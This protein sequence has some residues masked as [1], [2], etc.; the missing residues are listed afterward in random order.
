MVNQT[1]LTAGALILIHTIVGARIIVTA[2]CSDR[3]ARDTQPAT[4]YRRPRKGAG[5]G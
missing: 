5:R 2:W 1:R 3:Q 4:R